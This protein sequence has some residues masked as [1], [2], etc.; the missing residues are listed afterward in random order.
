[1][2]KRIYK[3]SPSNRTVELIIGDPVEFGAKAS[4]YF[5]IKLDS[6]TVKNFTAYGIDPIHSLQMAF[7]GADANLDFYA[8]KFG[9]DLTWLGEAD[10]G[11]A[12]RCRN[13]GSIIG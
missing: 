5:E 13:C 2:L 12:P 11:L 6:V 7:E 8:R 9:E 1:M 3:L 10:L 4:C